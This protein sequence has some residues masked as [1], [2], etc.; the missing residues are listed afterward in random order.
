MLFFHTKLSAKGHQSERE[1]KLVS[2]GAGQ[3][4]SDW[5]RHKNQPLYSVSNR[6]VDSCHEFCGVY[7]EKGQGNVFNKMGI[8]L[9]F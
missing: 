2:V 7:E 5:Q 9:K 6:A 4:G 3:A 8:Y 1:S